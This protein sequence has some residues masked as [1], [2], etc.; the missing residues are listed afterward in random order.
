MAV[1]HSR[2]PEH[3]GGG[4]VLEGAF[5]RS[6]VAWSVLSRLIKHMRIRV[7]ARQHSLSAGAGGVSAWELSS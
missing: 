5:E 1:E 2:G 7:R 6:D 3:P 4:E